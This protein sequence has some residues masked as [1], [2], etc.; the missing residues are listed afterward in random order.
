MAKTPPRDPY[1]TASNFKPAPVV[2]QAAPQAVGT[3]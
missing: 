1:K 2:P 3:D